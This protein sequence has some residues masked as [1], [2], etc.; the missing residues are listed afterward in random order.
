M[1]SNVVHCYFAQKVYDSL[2]A[3]AR[4]IIDKD[5][6]AFFVGAQGPD[7]MFYM[8]FRKPPINKLGEMLHDSFGTGELMRQSAAYAA[9]NDTDTMMPFIFG[10]LCHY[11][12]DSELHSYIYYRESDLPAHY[13]KSA[14]KYIHVVFESGL[15]YLCV[16]DYLKKNTKFYKAYKNL[17]ISAASRRAVSL[18]YS[19]VAAPSFGIDLPPKYPYKAI[20]LMRLFYRMLDDITG[21]RYIVIRGVEVILRSPQMVSAFIRPRKERKGE[22]WLNQSR[23]P[24]PKHRNLPHTVTHTVQEMAADAHAKALKLIYNFYGLAQ[25]KNELDG[26]LYAKNYCGDLKEL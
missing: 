2:N 19:R 14:H 26:S 5:K 24:F 12:L 3:E 1:P 9:A 7:L 8:R 20:N 17:N 23:M 11:A 25:G 4:A 21:I 16:R 13:P 18:Y 15:D 10:Q 22:D 6:Q